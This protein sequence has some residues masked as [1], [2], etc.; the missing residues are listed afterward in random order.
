MPSGNYIRPDFAG[1]CE[2]LRSIEELNVRKNTHKSQS[3]YRDVVRSIPP[4]K[5]EITENQGG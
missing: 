5:H 2:V 1:R 4:P 3:G